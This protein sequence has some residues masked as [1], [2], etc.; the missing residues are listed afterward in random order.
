MANRPSYLK[1][2]LNSFAHA[3]RGVARFI[4]KEEHAKVHLVAA[5]VVVALG[6][7][8]GVS[9]TEWMLL[10][11]AIGLVFTAEMA[12]S[13]IER[14]TDIAHPHFSEKAGLVKDL[15]AGAVL[16]AAIA[17]AAVGCLVFLPYFN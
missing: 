8:F 9:R 5:I 3:G 10:I 13:A 7:W 4:Q 12:N 16:L 14:L 1:R 17:A 2:R 11:L 6:C 15:A